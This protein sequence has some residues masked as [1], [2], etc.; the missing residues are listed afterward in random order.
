MDMDMDWPSEG[1]RFFEA[2]DTELQEAKRRERN[3]KKREKA[4]AR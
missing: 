2:H 1:L 4:K 3:R